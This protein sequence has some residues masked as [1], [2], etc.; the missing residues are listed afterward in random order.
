MTSLDT[1]VLRYAPGDGRGIRDRSRQEL[2]AFELR[3]ENLTPAPTSIADRVAD[4]ELRSRGDATTFAHELA[5]GFASVNGVR[6]SL[7]SGDGWTTAAHEDL[8]VSVDVSRIGAASA[9]IEVAPIDHLARLLKQLDVV[10]SSCWNPDAAGQFTAWW[11]G[12]SD[13]HG[14]PTHDRVRVMLAGAIDSFHAVR[15]CVFDLIEGDWHLHAF[16]QP[17]VAPALV[18]IHEIPVTISRDQLSLA[19]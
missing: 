9:R 8:Q 2:E 17:L 6:V 4:A 14:V 16:G 7:E 15:I 11:I 10:P 19:G 3:A 18:L 1:V 5:R 13:I 12:T